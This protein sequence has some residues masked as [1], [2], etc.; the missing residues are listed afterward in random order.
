MPAGGNQRK[1]NAKEG[2]FPGDIENVSDLKEH[3]LLHLC[4]IRLFTCWFHLLS[5]ALFL[6]S[7]SKAEVVVTFMS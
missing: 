6:S 1:D 2:L 3:L 4:T 5:L 7:G